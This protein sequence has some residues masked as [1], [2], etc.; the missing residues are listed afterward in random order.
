MPRLLRP[1]V[2]CVVPGFEHGASTNDR[3]AFRKYYFRAMRS[4]VDGYETQA[5]NRRYYVDMIYFG[6]ELGMFAG[7]GR[8]W[9]TFRPAGNDVEYEG[10]IAGNDITSANPYVICATGTAEQPFKATL[11]RGA[12][13]VHF[14]I[15]QHGGDL[16][17]LPFTPIIGGWV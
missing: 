9:S 13:H 14:A 12:E 4:L 11:C 7:V 16:G 15:L 5:G 6:D 3:A 10:T 8:G 2:F 1:S 17:V